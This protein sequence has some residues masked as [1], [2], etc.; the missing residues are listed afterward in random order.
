[1][2]HGKVTVACM[3]DLTKGFDTICHEILI[4]KMSS[5]MI[6]GQSLAWFK[7][8]LSL[9]SQYVKFN[10]VTSN[11]ETSPIGVPQGTI[12]GPILFLVY[13]NDFAQCFKQCKCIMYA[14]DTTIYFGI[15]NPDRLQ[16][17]IQNGLSEA[18]KW[19]TENC[20]VVNA[21]KSEFIILGNNSRME[22]YNPCFELP[23]QYNNVSTKLPSCHST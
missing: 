21:S 16:T 13:V 17:T 9:R 18:S 7:S 3:L 15:D 11:K 20:L 14:E 22:C 23:S 1:M 2:D 8:Y 4:H 10:N 6:R 12:L 19:L 5:Y